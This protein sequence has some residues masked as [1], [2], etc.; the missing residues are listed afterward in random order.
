MFPLKRILGFLSIFAL[1]YGL[2]IGLWFSWGDFYVKAFMA[3]GNAMF[4]SF[5]SSKGVVHFLSEEAVLRLKIRAP[6]L[7]NEYRDVTLVLVNQEALDA[8]EI[9]HKKK[10]PLTVIAISSRDTGYISA[11]LLIALALAT[12]IGWMRKGLTLLWGI[13][14][15][16]LFIIF[17]VA[18]LLLF[19]FCNNE[20]LAVM[21][22]SPFWQ[23][24]LDAAH[25]IFVGNMGVS[26]VVPVFIWI[27]VAF[28]R[29]DWRMAQ[30][31]KHRQQE[32]N[33]ERVNKTASEI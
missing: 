29:S 12:P 19:I 8:K 14:F 22:V 23:S 17:K 1:V 5:G 27:L 15:V 16:H 11:V 10:V 30:I 2:F 20:R 26:Y 18:I 33:C 21:F 32:M 31:G 13:I 24:V 6:Q 4:G 7:Y 3:A 28:R 25:E 9:D